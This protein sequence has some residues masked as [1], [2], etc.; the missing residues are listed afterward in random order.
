MRHVSSGQN[1]GGQFVGGRLAEAR[2]IGG[3]GK[4]ND[5]TYENTQTVWRTSTGDESIHQ[6]PVGPPT[7]VAKVF[8]TALKVNNCVR[9]HAN[10]REKI[11]TTKKTRKSFDGDK[12]YKTLLYFNS[13]YF[14][15]DIQSVDHFDRLF[16]PAI[17][18]RETPSKQRGSGWSSG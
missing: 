8:I 2:S 18:R 11:E 1:G 12:A 10:G 5:R 7:K 14:I 17:A 9:W 4:R 6:S 3:H 15:F 16:Q 13:D